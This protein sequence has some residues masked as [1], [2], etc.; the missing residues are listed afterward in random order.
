MFTNNAATG[1]SLQDVNVALVEAEDIV[2]TNADG[3]YTLSTN[4]TSAGTLEFSL[5]GYVTQTFPVDV[6]EGG[7]LTQ[8]AQLQ[9][10]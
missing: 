10:V 4:F 3:K 8:D 5:A 9:P 7:T 2:Q 6:A 1:L